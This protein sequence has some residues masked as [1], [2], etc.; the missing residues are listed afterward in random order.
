MAR[1]EDTGNTGLPNPPAPPR[2]GAN[3]WRLS[4]SA[5]Q[6]QPRL[7][8]QPLNPHPLDELLEHAYTEEPR[9][10]GPRAQGPRAQG[11]QTQQ[12]SP[13]SSAANRPRSGFAFLPI[14]IIGA[15]IIYRFFSDGRAG[16]SWIGKL[17]PLIVIAFI[18]HGWWQARQ[19]REAAKQKSL[20]AGE[21]GR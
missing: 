19:R 12:E 6:V 21:S 20:E 15:V 10:S 16:G 9:A 11:P 18:A 17:W 4:Q 1:L 13:P 3:P 8:T 14:V 5:Q 2:R 7:Q